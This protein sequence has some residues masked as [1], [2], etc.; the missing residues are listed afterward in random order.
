MQDPI[1]P[2]R[3]SLEFAE[4]I[5]HDDLVLEF[6]KDG[7]HGLSRDKDLARLFLL[8]EEMVKRSLA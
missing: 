4:R 1:V 6:I 3:R 8:L 5:N 7:D 2:W